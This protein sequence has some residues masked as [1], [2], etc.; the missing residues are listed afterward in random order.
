MIDLILSYLPSYLAIGFC[1]A[2]L[3]IF[4]M[5]SQRVFFG[6]EFYIFVIIFLWLPLLFYAAG[7]GFRDF[8]FENL[9]APCPDVKD[10]NQKSLTDFEEADS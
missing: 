5:S 9:L 4:S 6:M 7:L 8:L 1:L 3:I 2:M 10:K